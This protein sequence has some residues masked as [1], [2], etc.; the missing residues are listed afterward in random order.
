MERALDFVQ[1]S[2]SIEDRSAEQKL[3]PLAAGRGIAIMI[4]RP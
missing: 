4:N 2:Y 3:L 1:F